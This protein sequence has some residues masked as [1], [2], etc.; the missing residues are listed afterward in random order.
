MF[1]AAPGVETIRVSLETESAT[2]NYDP[3][4][5]DPDTLAGE[6]DGWIVTS[7]SLLLSPRHVLPTLGSVLLSVFCRLKT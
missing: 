2:I 4:V 3:S 1:S 5:T 7:E 6:S